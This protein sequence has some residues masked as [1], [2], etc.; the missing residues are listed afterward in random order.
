MPHIARYCAAG[1]KSLHSQIVSVLRREFAELVDSQP[2]LLAHHSA[3]AGMIFEAIEYYLSAAQRATAASNDTEKIAHIARGLSLLEQLP[4][5]DQGT[6]ELR[7]RLT[8]AGAL[9]LW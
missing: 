8:L 6:G 1:G 5:S 2:E 7:K 9:F 4:A 3:E